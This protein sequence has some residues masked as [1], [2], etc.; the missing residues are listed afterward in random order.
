MSDDAALLS[1]AERSR[2]ELARRHFV[3]YARL[4]FPRLVLGAWQEDLCAVLQ[5]FYDDVVASKSPC[6][7]CN[8]PSQFGKSMFAA[9][10]FP[11]WVLGKQSEWPI[12]LGAYAAT[13]SAGH[14]LWI[15]D[16]LRSPGHAEIFP[17][18][19]CRLH[20][21]SQARD[22]FRL[23]G[24]GQLICRGV[25]GGTTGFPARIFIVDDPYADRQ[26][27]E[28][29]TVRKSVSDWYSAVVST[30]VAP[31]GGKMLI[32]TRW[33]KDDLTGE[34]TEKSAQDPDA[35][36]YRSAIYRALASKDDRLGRA[37]GQ[38]LHP[39]RFTR[40]MLLRKRASM[41][42]PKDF[43]AIYQQDPVDA[44]G[45][46]FEV[47][48]INRLRELGTPN[49][50]RVY[51]GG[52]LALT[53]ERQNR[54]DYSVFVA[55]GVDF[56]KRRW[57]VDILRGRWSP[58]ECAK[59]LVNFALRWNA[60]KVW[61][62]NGPAFLGIRPSIITH[63]TDTGDFI[64]FEP[65]SHEGKSKDSR[66]IPF[67]GAVNS[68]L[69][70]VPWDAPWW[71]DFADELERFPGGTH[72]DQ[73]DAS[74]YLFTKVHRLP[75]DAQP[76]KPESE[77]PTQRQSDEARRNIRKMIAKRKEDRSPPVKRW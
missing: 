35:D 3:W 13:L 44:T 39:E 19:K 10:A 66:A 38:S 4:C 36:Q 59:N 25:G 32:H 31:G 20:E 60:R 30:R 65:V 5:Q 56:A 9:R 29:I 2:R 23:K 77:F 18:D 12:I 43:P 47:G 63:M 61:L 37:E 69:L 1:K 41:T 68:G 40:E 75:P 14:G 26:D 74:S 27:A 62:E 34:L 46:F 72:D 7:I 64:P 8:A 67:Q 21:D 55:G 51:I 73:V 49:L 16:R 50:D 52:D 48:K 53:P 45:G 17:D 58:A 42:N 76:V 15:R 11:A 33:S 24:G 57:I 54:G 28:S 22:E 6:Q 71:K 70:Y